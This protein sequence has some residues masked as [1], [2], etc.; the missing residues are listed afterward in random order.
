MTYS[1]TPRGVCSRQIDIDLDGDVIKE[2]R[3]IGGCDGNLTG[4]SR[5]IQGKTVN[6]VC[7]TLSGLTC[8]VKQTSCGDQLTKALREAHAAQ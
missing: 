7:D 5:L 6:E 8:G 3:F 2:V 4:I 1:F